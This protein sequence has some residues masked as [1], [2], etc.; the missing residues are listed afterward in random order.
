MTFRPI[1]VR[2][3][4]PHDQ[5]CP[6]WELVPDHGENPEL[7]Q[8]NSPFELRKA[9]VPV[10]WSDKR[11]HLEGKGTAF[12]LNSCGKFIS[13]EHVVAS[14][15]DEVGQYRAV[16][17]HYKAKMPDDEG[18]VVLLGMGLIYGKP[19]IPPHAL[20]RVASLWTLVFEKDDPIA[21]LQAKPEFNPIDITMMETKGANLELIRNL[22][23]R[24]RPPYPVV[25]E[26]V[27]AL[28]FP[29]IK[30]FEGTAEKAQTTISEQMHAAYGK[31][32]KLL[33]SG[34]DCTYR[35]P[36]FEVKAN[37]PSGMSGGPVLN[38]N[39]EVIG[40][41]SRSLEPSDGQPGVGWA[42]MLAGLSDFPNL[43]K[44]S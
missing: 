13:A 23:I 28:G 12:S 5:D 14:K 9:V 16:R 29:E 27:V 11:G 22:P 4:E 31:V 24:S 34:R 40:I 42:T 19:N 3:C 21:A 2:I 17:N 43:S 6:P 44:C 39:S 37:W 18:F 36:A 35:T 32:T 38:S 20:P 41:V 30:T 25:G 10:F 7:F 8:I 33:P 15:R 1:V 26:Q